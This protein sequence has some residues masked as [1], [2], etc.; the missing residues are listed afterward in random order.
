MSTSNKSKTVATSQRGKKRYPAAKLLKSKAL[1]G[2]QRDF[3]KVILGNKEYTVQEAKELLDNVLNPGA[4]TGE[5]K[6][7]E[8]NA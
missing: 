4:D 1:S 7:E 2:Y 3:A 8:A 6:G 5:E